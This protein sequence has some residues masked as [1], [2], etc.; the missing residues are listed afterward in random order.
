MLGQLQKI[1]KALML[2]IAV[3]P[4]AGLLLRLGQPDTLNIPF[5]A[6]AGSA[7][8]NFL[9]IL[10]AI[11][12]AVGFAKNNHGFA[13][14]AGFVSYEI[15]TDGAT[16]INS[17][18]NLDA[19]GGILAGIITGVIFNAVTKRKE[20]KWAQFMGEPRDW[21]SCSSPWYPSSW[22]SSSATFGRLYR[23]A[24]TTSAVGLAPLAR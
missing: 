2:P 3:L 20:A 1:G 13:G 23:R 16:A 5:M 18:I 8:F 6:A 22:R 7:V 15:L 21:R 11:G 12:V 17:T 9:P 4:A 14:L 10:F 24:S 19:L